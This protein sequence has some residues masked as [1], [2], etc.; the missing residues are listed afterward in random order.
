[1]STIKVNA[2][3]H[4]SANGSN[5]TLFANG[6]VAMTTANTTLTVGS[7][8]ISNSG[9]SVA[10]NAINPFGGMRNRIINGDMRIDQRN[11]GASVTPSSGVTYFLD[12][13]HLNLAQSSKVSIQQ[14]AGSVTP[15]AG[16]SNYVGITSLSSYSIVSGDYHT[17]RQSIEG[18]N[19]A[20]LAWGTS[21]AKTI[22]VSFWVRSSLTGTFG[23]SLN[24]SDYSRTYAF[25]YTISSANTWTYI[26]IT[27]PGDTTGTWSTTN[28]TGIHIGFQLGTGSSYTTTAGSWV[29][30]TYLGATGATSVIGTS[31]ATFY[32]T[33]VQLEAGTVATPFEFRQYGQEL[34]L[35]KRYYWQIVTGTSLD[36]MLNG[37]NY[38]S[39]QWESVVTYPVEMRAV[40]SITFTAASTF[41]H[42]TTTTSPTTTSYYY[43]DTTLARS[44]I[45][46]YFVYSGLTQ[47]QAGI[48]CNKGPTY[49]AGIYFN[50]EL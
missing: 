6:N 30:A 5:M 15:P 45:L 7:T 20:D 38:Q 8:T 31:G 35:C 14:N 12:R 16:F 1:M 19:I 26:T 44:Q 49:A 2:I 32:L 47:G 22:T 25:T 29:G 9:I 37:S 36:L 4:T 41:Y 23:G 21:S 28:S 34:L 48:M 42:R 50:A 39:N 3:Q 17:I 10:G 24:N 33:G 18:Y 11:A 46:I 27:I 13:W 43:T 40:P